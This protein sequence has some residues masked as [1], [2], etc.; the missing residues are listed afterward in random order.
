MSSKDILTFLVLMVG[1]LD[2]VPYRFTIM[3]ILNKHNLSRF[4]KDGLLKTDHGVY[5]VPNGWVVICIF[6]LLNMLPKSGF[7][8][9]GSL[10]RN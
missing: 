8:K 4:P 6:R 9:V 5:F 1:L 10:N 7:R 2:T 3:G